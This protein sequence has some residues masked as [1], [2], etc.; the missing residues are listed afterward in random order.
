M[1]VIKI[2]RIVP[3]YPFDAYAHLVEPVSAADG[4]GFLLSF[5]DL[6]GCLSDGATIEAAIAN[7][8]DAFVSWMSAAADMGAPI[9]PPLYR[10]E[11]ER[12]LS[13]RFVQ[14]VPKT[15]HARLQGRAKAEG[16]SVNQLVTTY[17]AECLGRAR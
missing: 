13:G 17:I 15:L 14:R 1:S 4:G 9:P 5:P 7:G 3:P 12:N 11:G 6:P 2:P 16:V 8:R 10:H